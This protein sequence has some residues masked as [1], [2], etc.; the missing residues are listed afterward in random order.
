MEEIEFEERMGLSNDGYLRYLV[1][2]SLE[3]YNN[4]WIKNLEYLDQMKQEV[5][6]LEDCKVEFKNHSDILTFIDRKIKVWSDI[7]DET[8][9][10]KSEDGKILAM[11]A[12]A[13]KAL[14]K[15]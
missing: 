5:K 10:K 3:E 15:L 1:G 2:I 6:R 14:D 7:I 12:R 11:I 8:T 9:K 4:K 13:K